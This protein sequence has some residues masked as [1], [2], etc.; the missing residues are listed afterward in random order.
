MV[1]TNE[2]GELTLPKEFASVQLLSL[3]YTFVLEQVYTDC[4][5]VASN[6]AIITRSV[7]ENRIEKGQKII[8]Y[9]N[10]KK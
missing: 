1:T 6:T 2:C 5:F 3:T 9:R 7:S 10:N 8:C 4:A